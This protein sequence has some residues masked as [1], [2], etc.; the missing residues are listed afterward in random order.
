MTV[1]K[2]VVRSCAAGY[3]FE[4]LEGRGY[5]TGRNNHNIVKTVPTVLAI[6][7]LHRDGKKKVFAR[8]ELLLTRNVC[9]R[10]R[11]VWGVNMSYST[12]AHAMIRYVESH[13]ESFDISEMSESFGFSEIYLRELF[14]KNVDMPIMRYYKRRRIIVSAFEILHSDRKIVDIALESGFSNHESYTRAFRKTFGVSPS[15]FRIDRPMIGRKQLDTGVFG[16]ERLV[17]KEKRSDE[18]T[19]EQNDSTTILYGIRRI[20][21]GAYGSNTMFPICVKAVSEY[22]GDDVSYACIMAA[23][24]AAFRLV[25]NRAVW[26]LSNIDIY[27]AL[28]ESNE[29]YKYGARALGREFDFLGRDENTKKEDFA[30]FIR[31]KIAKGFPVIALVIIGPPEPCII[32]GYEESGEIVAGW[33]F[34]Q[35]DDEFSSEISLM[36]NGY[37]RSDKWWENTDTQ[38]VMCIGPVSDNA[39]CGD[40][41]IVQMALAVMEARNEGTYAKGISAYDAWKDM[42]LEEKWFENGAGFD[43]LFSKLLV[44][45]DATVCIRDGRRW[46]A[47]YLEALSEKCGET[48]KGICQKAAGHFRK[49]SGIAGDMMSLIGSWSDMEK[50]LGNFGDR[51]VRE[52]LGKLIDAARAEDTMAYEQM[53]LLLN[54]I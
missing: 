51:S 44:Q 30:A 48:E 45:N 33:N 52:K 17:G 25:W 37:F 46:G 49:V 22:L 10:Q 14:R 54:S 16:L 4:R 9:A 20:R 53:R 41:E 26:D 6:L 23:T 15:R 18:L 39:P 35:E 13:L 11:R 31:S 3:C 50:A 2:H 24:G 38:A 43:H 5:G 36:D 1:P 32:A 28:R 19:M 42:L 47:E 29:I 21:H 40:R 12:M 7:I 34:F 8:E 27:H